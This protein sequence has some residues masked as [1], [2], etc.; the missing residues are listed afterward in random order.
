[1]RQTPGPTPSDLGRVALSDVGGPFVAWL[2]ERG[3]DVSAEA[4]LGNLAHVVGVSVFLRDGTDR[5]VGTSFTPE[6]VDRTVRE[7][8]P[9]MV[10]DSDLPPEAGDTL[11]EALHDYLEFLDETGRWTGSSA[12]YEGCHEI[13]HEYAEPGLELDQETLDAIAAVGPAEEDDALLASLPVRAAV[14]LLRQAREGLDPTAE[15]EVTAAF[16]TTAAELGLTAGG[17]EDVPSIVV[18][19]WVMAHAGLTASAAD[20]RRTTTP[21][22]LDL[23]DAST[24]ARRWRREVVGRLIRD[25]PQ[26]EGSWP[27][28]DVVPYLLVASVEGEVVDTGFIEGVLATVSP[29][30]QLN[31]SALGVVEGHLREL[32]R[33]GITSPAE[34]WTLAPGFWPAALWGLETSPE[35]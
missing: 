34:P 20:D 1:M 19:W 29:D 16:L 3:V 25:D 18:V 9:A 17:V 8:V 11:V 22:G 24:E 27:V 5:T 15:D 7:F 32:G 12:G 10:R 26:A 14:S 28:G 21:P 4:A 13:L 33:L 23:A 35:V 6:E 2:A 31:R 30:A